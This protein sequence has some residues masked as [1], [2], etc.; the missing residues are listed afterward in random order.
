[1]ATIRYGDVIVELLELCEE[2]RA[3]IHQH[4]LF[5][6]ASVYK[7]D[8]AKIINQKVAHLRLIFSIIGNDLLHDAIADFDAMSQLS[9]QSAAPGE[10]P[11]TAR[12]SR[13]SATIEPII[14]ELQRRNAN[15][16]SVI[17]DEFK[18]TLVEHRRALLGICRRGTRSWELLRSLQGP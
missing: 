2:I 13:L 11:L 14:K 12:V 7:T 4:L 1:M 16:N 8:G 15:K 5:Y 18:R 10:C 3:D 9:A 6:R 17:R